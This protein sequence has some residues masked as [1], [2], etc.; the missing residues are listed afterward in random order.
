MYQ[1]DLTTA[2]DLSTA[3]FANKTLS[4]GT[5]TYDVVFS[6]DGTT[7][8]A[9]YPSDV[10][11]FSLTTPFDITTATD[12]GSDFEF[13]IASTMLGALGIGMP[14]DGSHMYIIGNDQFV[15]TGGGDTGGW[16]ILGYQLDNNPEI[17]DFAL[18]E[19][20]NPSSTTA[21]FSL[22]FTEFFNSQTIENEF[23]KGIIFSFIERDFMHMPKVINDM[24]G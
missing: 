11:I 21:S 24:Y 4:A 12:L 23:L 13:S 1:F 19:E 16:E 6:A 14:K 10:H 2:Y 7:M 5:N 8:V 20:R 22:T 3:S 9:L 17:E 18:A 15:G